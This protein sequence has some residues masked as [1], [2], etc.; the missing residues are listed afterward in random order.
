MTAFLIAFVIV[1]AF[2]FITK[3]GRS[4]APDDPHA[5][6]VPSNDAGVLMRIQRGQPIAAIKL[7]REIHN[8]GLKEAK[9]AVEA[10]AAGKKPS[11]PPAGDAAV[12]ADVVSMIRS[13]NMIDAIRMYR[14]LHGTDLVTAKNA[15]E[16]LAKTLQP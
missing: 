3:G 11:A 15:V 6:P 14:E 10:M 1:A 2:F 9:D 7:Y 13:G 8:V 12:D 5:P 16:A 4:E